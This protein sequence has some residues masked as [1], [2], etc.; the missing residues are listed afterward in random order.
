MTREQLIALCLI[1]MSGSGVGLVILQFVKAIRGRRN[2]SH[3][4]PY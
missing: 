3:G 2:G 4:T 1:V